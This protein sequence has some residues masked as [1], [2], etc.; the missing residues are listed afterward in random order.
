MVVVTA[1]TAV[2]AAGCGSSGLSKQQLASN[3]N[4]I[5]DRF[6]PRV[7]AVKAPSD[8]LT[9]PASAAHY[10]DQIAPLYGQALD[11]LKKLK[12]A[13]NVKSQW[14]QML[15]RF[16]AV[17]SLTDQLKAEADKGQTDGT[18]LLSQVVPRSNAAD[19]A[20]SQIG[21][22]SCGSTPT[23]SGGG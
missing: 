10:F 9:N 17:A 15:S 2:V 22:T 16:G 3:A 12:P 7:A 19:A 13:S 4:T 8:V 11:E 21:A 14:S 23:Q 20:A 5:C 6:K 18:V 1:L